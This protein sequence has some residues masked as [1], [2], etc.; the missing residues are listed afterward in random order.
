[1]T[2]TH[3]DSAA[4]AGPFVLRVGAPING[5][6][7]IVS[8]EAVNAT[9]G[10]ATFSG[11]HL[12]LNQVQLDLAAQLARTHEVVVQAKR[13]AGER[14]LAIFA[15]GPMPLLF[16]LGYWLGDHR[17]LEV[18]QPYRLVPP[19]QTW[20]WA[21]EPNSLCWKNGGLQTPPQVEDVVV[22]LS[23]SGQIEQDLV[24]RAMS[25]RYAIYEL[26]LAN[27]LPT[28]RWTQE[29]VT[30]FV[31]HWHE[32][33]GRIGQK[34]G[35]TA[36]IHLFPALPV[37]MCVRLGCHALSK[38]DP[39][40]HVYD[41]DDGDFHYCLTLDRG[42]VTINNGQ[43]NTQLSVSSLNGDAIE[44]LNDLGVEHVEQ[45]DRDL[46]EPRS[47]RLVKALATAVGKKFVGDVVDEIGA[48]VHMP[49]T[50]E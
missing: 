20:T 11:C 35:S 8:A 46:V 37:A 45:K 41:R 1:M 22:L 7:S 12:N 27:P 26:T 25:G 50:D 29:D 5:S 13:D 2:Q 18:F 38:K 40:I 3:T 9:L 15:L 4:D 24:G 43:P 49:S 34:F 33:L 6:H 10:V 47:K 48:S 42:E 30:H 19:S 23:V 28:H 36:R 17:P 16:A 31:K 21:V 32:L 44:R 14:S 39:S